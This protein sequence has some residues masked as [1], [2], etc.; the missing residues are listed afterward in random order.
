MMH[1]TPDSARRIALIICWSTHFAKDELDIINNSAWKIAFSC[2]L[3]G[4][5]PSS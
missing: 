2:L 3:A 5:M 1:A 4:L